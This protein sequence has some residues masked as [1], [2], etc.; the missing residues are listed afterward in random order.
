MNH[1]TDQVGSK[2]TAAA[3]ALLFAPALHPLLI[4]VVGVPSHLM[5]WVHVLPVALIA[6]VFGRRG[7]ALVMLASLGLVVVGERLF[8]AGYGRPADGHTVAA[9]AVALGFT[10]LLVV[11]FALYARGMTRRYRLLFDRSSIGILRVDGAGRIQAANPA[12][13]EL[14]GLDARS[15]RGRPFDEALG[16]DPPVSLREIERTSGWMGCLPATPG[17]NRSAYV[18]VVAVGQD[19]ASGWQVL[20][21]DRTIEV[22]QEQE[23]ER[24]SRLALL[25]EGLAGVAHEIKNPLM[26][27]RGYATILRE[28]A[29]GVDRE[30]ELLRIIEEQTDRIDALVMDLLGL[31]RPAAEA[32]RFAV[33][34]LVEKIGRIQ[35]VALGKAVRI[36]HRLDW[37]GEIA[38]SPAK[39]EQILLNLVSNAADAVPAHAGEIRLVCR[40]AGEWIEFEVVDNGPGLPESLLDSAFQPYVTTKPAGQGTG[41]GLAISRRLAT[42]MGGSLEARNLNPGGAAFTLRLPLHPSEADANTLAL[43]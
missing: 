14:L 18:L 19:E 30:R 22:V 21:V 6:Y 32:K 27:I 41:L 39:V 7:A 17:R 38:A 42:A 29:G 40:R 8:G 4:P 5:W 37:N 35:Q 26:V 20:L 34:A 10:N 1:S 28:S 31:A 16:I 15:L 33:G 24:T 3:V 36:V 25:G 9:L 11:G 2:G 43:A 12:A 13:V 23:L